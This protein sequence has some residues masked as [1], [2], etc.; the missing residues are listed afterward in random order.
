MT[1][2]PQSYFSATRIVW[3]ES[4]VTA[5][6]AALAA[7]GVDRPLVIVDSA[8]VSHPVVSEAIQR[9]VVATVHERSGSEPETTE[10]DALC[11][12]G[13]EARC[14]GV[15][16][17]G[18]GSVLDLAK[19]VGGLV[20]AAGNAADYQGFNLLP[21][22]AHPVIA[23]P[24]TAGTGSEVTGTAVLVNR[25]KA[26]K[27]GINSP[28]IVPKVAI[29]EPRLV[30]GLPVGLTLTAGMDAISHAVE[31]YSARKATPISR[32]L[33]IGAFRLLIDAVDRALRHP[34]DLH[35][36][37]ATLI[38]STMAGL[39]VMNAGTGAAHAMAYPLGVHLGVPHSVALAMLLP[40]IVE[41]CERVQPDVYAEEARL[42]G[43][44]VSAALRTLVE[45]WQDE[46]R[47]ARFGQPDIA[48][49]AAESMNLVSAVENHP[50]PFS[51]NDA[52]AI[53]E[54]IA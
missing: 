51:E 47:L 6:G 21:G 49:L 38:G 27:L 1:Q 36:R 4:L 34:D 48:L 32:A 40:E 26:M 24:T 20:P 45:P 41:S 12:L 15:I 42:A 11:N 29:L 37:E 16:G 30:A 43:G 31:S 17:I 22:P 18:G 35:A 2:I 9:L 8:V 52:R 19:A 53:L 33:S 10:A 28:H 7:H 13:R 46:L 23:V 54:A 5:L 39:A 44:S 50:V 3:G 14:D 25:A